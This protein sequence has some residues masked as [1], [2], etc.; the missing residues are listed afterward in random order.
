TASAHHE[1]ADRGAA[2]RAGLAGAAVDQEAI[3]E[4]A[5]GTVDV[6]EVVDRR[7]LGLDAGAER[8]LDPDAQALPVAG[9]EPAG[10]PQR[11]DPGPE[12]GLVGIDVAHA[13]DSLLVEHER[14]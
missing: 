12:E 11:M 14:L 13:G 7:A 5:A 4:R 6:A 10:R 2:A 1:L 3:L 8:L 9:G